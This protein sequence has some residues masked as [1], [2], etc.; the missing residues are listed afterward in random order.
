MKEYFKWLI[1]NTRI[2]KATFRL[3]W[4]FMYLTF[5]FLIIRESIRDTPKALFLL[6]FIG[7]MMYYQWRHFKSRKDG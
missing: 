2:R 3:F 4:F 5:L 6:P 7:A 1:A